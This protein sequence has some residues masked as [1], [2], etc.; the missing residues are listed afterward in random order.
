MAVSYDLVIKRS[1]YVTR[2]PASGL[3][4]TN[5]SWNGRR[6]QVHCCGS[7]ESLGVAKLCSV[8]LQLSIYPISASAPQRRHMLISSLTPGTREQAYNVMNNSSARSSDSFLNHAN[9]FRRLLRFYVI[10]VA[11]VFANLP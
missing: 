8:R 6:I 9:E 7:T 11:L 4:R 1:R 5:S 10:S 3:L 2:K